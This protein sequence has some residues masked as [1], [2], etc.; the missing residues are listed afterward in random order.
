MIREL[1]FDIEI[2]RGVPVTGFFETDGERVL[3]VTMPDG[4]RID[5]R[6]HECE[7]DRVMFEMIRQQLEGQYGLI[8]FYA[9]LIEYDPA[10]DK[11]DMDYDRLSAA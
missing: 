2:W 11:A 10:D 3:S 6:R 4:A 1:P 9:E 8:D 7:Q 5:R